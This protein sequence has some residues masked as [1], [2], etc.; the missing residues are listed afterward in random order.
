MHPWQWQ[1]DMALST[2]VTVTALLHCRRSWDYLEGT[3]N[4]FIHKAS[5][6][7]FFTGSLSMV[8]SAESMA[9]L[10]KTPVHEKTNTFWPAELIS[11]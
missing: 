1:T 11:R 5:L 8:P 7:F 9:C 3:S 6:F 2:A 10:C 4:V